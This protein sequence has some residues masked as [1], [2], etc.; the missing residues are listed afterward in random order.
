MKDNKPNGPLFSPEFR[1]IVKRLKDKEPELEAL[2]G[3][4]DRQE[5]RERGQA[6]EGENPPESAR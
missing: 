3:L 1:E 4:D 6:D 2:A 5:S